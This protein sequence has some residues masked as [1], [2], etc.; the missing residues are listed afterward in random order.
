[1]NA[2]EVE[3]LRIGVEEIRLIVSTDTKRRTDFSED[4]NSEN[5]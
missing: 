2:A 5:A 4:S 1:M 3:N